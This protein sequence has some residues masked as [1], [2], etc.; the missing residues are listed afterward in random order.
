MSTETYAGLV[1]RQTREKD[2]VEA[3]GASDMNLVNAKL[4]YYPH[5]QRRPDVSLETAHH[6]IQLAELPID[7]QPTEEIP[8]VTPEMLGYN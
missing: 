1:A 6:I 5:G 2:I 8:V 4:D 3:F 7:R